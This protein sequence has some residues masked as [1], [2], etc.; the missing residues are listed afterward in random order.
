[1]CYNVKEWHEETLFCIL[2]SLYSYIF[3][4]TAFPRYC[5]EH[6]RVLIFRRLS[7]D[8]RTYYSERVLC[9][10][11]TATSAR[12]SLARDI[13]QETHSPIRHRFFLRS[14][15][16][17]RAAKDMVLQPWKPYEFRAASLFL[18]FLPSILHKIFGISKTYS[19]KIGY[20]FRIY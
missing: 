18:L 9:F 16:G 15:H 20:N 10:R 6:S 2:N 7:S 12:R 1:M 13:L 17:R 8:H 14:R 19:K 5:G 3:A 11:H 4:L